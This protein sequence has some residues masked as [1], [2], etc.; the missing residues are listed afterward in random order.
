MLD[1]VSTEGHVCSQKS[2]AVV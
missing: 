2:I 1:I